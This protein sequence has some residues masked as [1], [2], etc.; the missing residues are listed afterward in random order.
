[1]SLRCF[2]YKFIGWLAVTHLCLL[3]LSTQCQMVKLLEYFGL[4]PNYFLYCSWNKWGARAIG[5][6]EKKKSQ[7]II[8]SQVPHK[9]DLWFSNTISCG[10]IWAG[11][12]DILESIH[13]RRK[14]LKREIWLFYFFFSS[15]LFSPVSQTLPRNKLGTL[16]HYLWAASGAGQ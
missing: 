15:A 12:K 16:R 3:L 11:T 7:S 8:I 4:F 6:N 2:P 1:M 14:N 13:N 10:L 9:N 5:D